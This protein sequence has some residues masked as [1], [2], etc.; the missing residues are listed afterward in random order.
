M[1]IAYDHQIFSWQE[2][3]GISRYFFEVATRINKIRGFDVSVVSPFFVNKYL[4]GDRS[5]KVWG[6]QVSRYPRPQRITWKLNKALVWWKLHHEPPDLVH[7]TSYVTQKLSSSKTRTILTVFDMIH[8]KFRE[9]FPTDSAAPQ[10]KR[11]AVARADHIICISENTRRDLVDIL[12]V[13]PARTSVTHLAPST[14][15]EKEGENPPVTDRPYIAYVGLRAGYKNFSG[16]IR[17]FASSEF[18]RNNFSIVCFGGGEFTSDER[19]EMSRGGLMADRVIHVSGGDEMLKPI[20]RSATVFV[21]PSLYEGFGIPPLE[22]MA[23]N[24]PVVASNTGSV[25]EVCGAAAEYFDPYQPESIANAIERVVTSTGRRKELT[26]LGALQIRKY[27]WD[28]CANQTAEVYRLVA[29][30]E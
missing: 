2:Y 14:L 11:A 4:H 12:K 30:K 24:C 20:Y 5:I 22:A 29:N 6:R 18:L 27:S 1:R 13:D 17:A 21:Y 26:D 8:E 9:M 16:L 3:G 23:A 28:N 7:E 10:M 19:Q 25:P 15:P